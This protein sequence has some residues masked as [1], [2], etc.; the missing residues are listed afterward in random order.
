MPLSI[1][2][3]QGPVLIIKLRDL[4]AKSVLGRGNYEINITLPSSKGKGT[5]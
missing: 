2:P 1:A 3:P 5:G 4:V